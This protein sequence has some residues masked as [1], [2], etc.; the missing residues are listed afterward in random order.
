M[1][2]KTILVF[3]INV[4]HLSQE[5]VSN[6]IERVR[7]MVKPSEKD[8]DDV[9]SYI[10]PVRDQETRVECINAPV[11]VASEI[12]KENVIKKI[13]DVDRKLDRIT[14]HINASAEMRKVII[15]KH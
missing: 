10:I 6:T 2:N 13:E 3:Y 8:N 14:A 11:F 12:M 9:V 5:E 7:E 4:G 1:L 15:E